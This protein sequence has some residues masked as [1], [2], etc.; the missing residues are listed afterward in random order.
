MTRG[1]R[2]ARDSGDPG[3]SERGR[4]YI[5][6]SCIQEKYKPDRWRWPHSP[7]GE[8]WCDSPLTVRT[9]SCTTQFS[10]RKTHTTHTIWVSSRMSFSYQC[11][12]LVA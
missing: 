12:P 1:E 9:T 11:I 4:S 10:A 5:H 8:I 6:R 3:A 7:T 2:K